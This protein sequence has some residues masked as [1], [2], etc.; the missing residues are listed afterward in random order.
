MGAS[1]FYYIA[2]G[3]DYRQVFRELVDEASFMYGHE[4][5]NGTISTTDLSRR[6]PHKIADR[7]TATAEKKALAYCEKVGWGK[8]WE[9]RVLDLGIT[10]YEISSFV[11]V[12]H[13]TADAQFQTRYVVMA[14]DRVL[15]E[16]KTAAEARKALEAA[17]TRPSNS[18][19]DGFRVVKAARNI[20]H[21]KTTACAYERKTR[22]TKTRPKKVPAGATVR[23]VH[24]WMFYGWASC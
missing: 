4:D 5:Y 1:N 23:E 8:K 17:L 19:V 2:E 22:I 20:N 3:T 15:G 16:Y 11:K 18:G 24:S 7:Y 21:G 6:T 12:P 13:T 10:G 14:D 9:S